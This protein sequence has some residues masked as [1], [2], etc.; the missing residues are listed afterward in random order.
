MKHIDADGAVGASPFPPIAD[1]GF[2]SDCE[3]T[4]LVAPSGNV[5][6]M[7]LPRM[8]SPSVFG[9]I[10]DRDAGSFRAR[11]RRRGGARRAPLPAGHD[12]ARDQ[13]GHP[14]RLDH[15][16]RR[17][18]D[19]AVAPR[20]RALHHPPPLAHRLRRRPRAA[21]PGAVRERR[22]AAEP[23]LRAGRSTTGA[24]FAKWEYT[25]PGYH[26]AVATADGIRP[27]AH[28]HQ[29]HEH[30][31]RGP[32]RHRPHDDEGGRHPVR[33]AVVV[34]A[35]PAAE[36]RRG[37]RAAGVDRPPLA[38]LA[39]PRRVP[40]P[41]VAHLPPAQRAHAEGPLLSPRRAR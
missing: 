8:D 10:L 2:L 21:A 7:C 17:A 15:R 31:L 27:A 39:R 6:W 29:R 33:R 38:A 5:E 37:L 4:A 32:A 30:R 14:R 13:L 22:G 35:P 19:R 40:R 25:G 26:E 41:P 34:R 3:T 18:A 20:G 16:A 12:G 1:Y 11:P 23:R 36:L 9:A 24:S 28:A